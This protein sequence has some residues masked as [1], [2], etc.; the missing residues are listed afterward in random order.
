MQGDGKLSKF[1]PV[2]KWS[3]EAIEQVVTNNLLIMVKTDGKGLT[4]EEKDFDK[5]LKAEYWRREELGLHIEIDC[6]ICTDGKVSYYDIAKEFSSDTNK[7]K[8][9]ICNKHVNSLNE[10]LAEFVK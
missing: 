1:L 4:Q 10:K 8:K 3:D 6:M 5:K 9:N 7:I 2:E